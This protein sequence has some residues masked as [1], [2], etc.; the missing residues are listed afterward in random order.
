MTNPLNHTA[1]ALIAIALMIPGRRL[2]LFHG[3]WRSS[4]QN[5]TLMPSAEGGEI[6]AVKLTPPLRCAQRHLKYS[7]FVSNFHE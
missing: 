1:I 2:A 3:R 7:G 6:L 5:T 4:C